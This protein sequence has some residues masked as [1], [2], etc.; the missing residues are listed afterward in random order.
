MVWRQLWRSRTAVAGGIITALFVIVAAIG[1][2]LVAQDPYRQSLADRLKPP[3]VEHWMGTDE[4]G[5]DILSR[6]VAGARLSLL[7]S[8]AATTAALVVGAGLGLVSAYYGRLVER[9]I[10]GA[11]DVLLALP[12]IL[13]ALTIIATLGVG[14]V[15]LVAAIA[16]NGVP[17]LA[18]L[19]HGCTL[20]TKEE[21]YVRAARALGASDS[22]ILALHILPNIAAPL[23][24]QFSLRVAT[25]VLLASSLSFL[26]LGAQ[27]PLPEWGAMLS[28]ARTYM[29]VSPHV[30][31]F[32]G[33][34]IMF[35]VLGLNLLGDGLR[36]A[37]D[38][39]LR[40]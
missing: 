33:L 17:T 4:V 27:P 6:I 16:I 34:T 11:M 25:A 36:D 5:R 3:S 21:D 35:V 12:G 40:R 30:A 10:M 9:V 7:L 14:L 13:I 31:L 29:R 18:R 22:R 24:V 26:G 1:P 19:A 39:R 28:E 38:P 32:P 37:L 20:R 15:N 23:I 2:F 8:L